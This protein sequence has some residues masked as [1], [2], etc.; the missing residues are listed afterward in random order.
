MNSNP[1]LKS[2]SA[3]VTGANSGIGEAVAIALANDGANV[4]VNYVTHPENADNVI[5]KIEK[6]GGKAIAIKADASDHVD[7]TFTI[8]F[9]NTDII[10]SKIKPT[11]SNDLTMDEG[12]T[13]SFR[14]Q[15]EEGSF[16]LESITY[17]C[18]YPIRSTTPIDQ[19]QLNLL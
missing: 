2:Q 17:F 10:P 19:L 3:L 14:L 11:V 8:L 5:K 9:Y 7:T 16:P 6:I 13:L 12:D 4:V 15:C 18:N 1:K